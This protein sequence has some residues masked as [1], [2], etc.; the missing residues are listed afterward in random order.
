MQN[1][2][3]ILL[4][5]AVFIQSYRISRLEKALKDER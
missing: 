3:D 2:I 5:V 4:I 1:V